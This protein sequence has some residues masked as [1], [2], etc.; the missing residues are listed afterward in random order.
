MANK[1]EIYITMV[2]YA[3][4]VSLLFTFYFGSVILIKYYQEHH[5][6]KFKEEYI[7]T[8]YTQE[9]IPPDVLLKAKN[10]IVFRTATI[11]TIC[12]LFLLEYLKYKK[13]PKEHFFAQRQKFTK[14]L[15]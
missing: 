15:S 2:K 6:F 3:L 11:I 7:Y 10:L 5:D 12:F 9:Q 8:A 4:I 14:S 13:N 1:I